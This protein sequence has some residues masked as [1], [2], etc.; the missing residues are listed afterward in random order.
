MNCKG[1]RYQASDRAREVAKAKNAVAL[2][3]QNLTPV[4]EWKKFPK[5]AAR[6]GLLNSPSIRLLQFRLARSDSFGCSGMVDLLQ[7]FFRIA[8]SFGFVNEW[9]KRHVG[10]Q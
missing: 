9:L 3:N 5:A 8:V 2:N 6:S 4:P 7:G 10:L 1:F